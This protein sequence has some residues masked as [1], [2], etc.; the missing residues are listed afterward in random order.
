MPKVLP[1]YSGGRL[2]GRSTKEKGREG[3]V[4][5]DDE[6]RNVRSQ[7]DQKMVACTRTR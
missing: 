3:A 6:E 2:P 4:D 1:D 7:I 5:E